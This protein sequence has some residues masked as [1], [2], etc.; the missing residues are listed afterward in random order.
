MSTTSSSRRKPRTTA[1]SR[2]AQA[3]ALGAGLALCLGCRGGVQETFVTDF[4][5]D[6]GLSLRHPASWRT[7]QA[8]QAGVWYRY[9]LAPPAGPQNRAPVSV[10]LLA[11]ASA[12]SV[13]DYAQSYLAGHT[14]TSSRAEERQ[15]VPGKSWVFASADGKTRYRLLLLAQDGRV[16][17]LYAQ[18]DAVAVEKDAAIL[19]EMWASLAIERPDR[20]PRHTWPAFQASLGVPE[21]WRQTR[22]FSGRGT[23]L[24]QFASPPLGLEKKQTVHAALSVTLERAPE[25][26]GLREYYDATRRKLGDNYMVTSHQAFRGGYVDVMKTETPL[27]VSFIKRYY[28][29]DGA[30]ACSLSFEAREDVF[31]RAARWGDYIASTLRLGSVAA[32]AP[33]ATAVT[34]EAR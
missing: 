11:G 9:F 16:A 13:D 22:E 3:F 17:G 24:V 21:S 30:A 15:G 34:G 14:I 33:T 18:G 31:P 2:R 20:Y 1:W 4:N 6:H 29:T 25:G 12:A 10:T 19:D 28:F 7:D 26:G 32:A 23:T 27:A 8:E 5:G